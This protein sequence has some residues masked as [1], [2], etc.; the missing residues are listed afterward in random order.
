MNRVT[1]SKDTKAYKELGDVWGVRYPYPP[2]D[3]LADMG[4]AVFDEANNLVM[5]EAYV[6]RRL[7][8]SDESVDLNMRFHD[9]SKPPR[10]PNEVIT[11]RFI[12]PQP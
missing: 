6:M 3:V 7:V 1:W 10:D 5:F 8:N 9:R 4:W 2:A 11:V 12:S